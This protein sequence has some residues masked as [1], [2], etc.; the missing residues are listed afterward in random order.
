MQKPWAGSLKAEVNLFLKQ[1]WARGVTTHQELPSSGLKT[2]SPCEVTL[3]RFLVQ[4]PSFPHITNPPGT[5]GAGPVLDP[6]P[7]CNN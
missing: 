7:R 3:T 5:P 1:L 2:R 4:R 6:F